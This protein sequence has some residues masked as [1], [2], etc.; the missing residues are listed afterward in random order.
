MEEEH[1]FVCN[2]LR[3]CLIFLDN[4]GILEV[5]IECGKPSSITDMNFCCH[6]NKDEWMSPSCLAGFWGFHSYMHL[7]L[8]RKLFS[9]ILSH[10]P[11]TSCAILPIVS[12]ICCVHRIVE[13][14]G[15]GSAGY[16]VH[17][18]VHT[19][20]VCCVKLLQWH[21]FWWSFGRLYIKAVTSIGAEGNYPLP[22]GEFLSDAPFSNLVSGRLQS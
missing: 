5:S 4:H 14:S 22:V 20:R 16:V 12:S 21:D 19:W 3:F 11:Y 17:V 9:A 15:V 13:G 8:L 18:D 10:H 6:E 1:S 2:R 7:F